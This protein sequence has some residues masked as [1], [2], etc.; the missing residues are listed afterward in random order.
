MP[1]MRRK[2]GITGFYHVVAKGDGA[3]IIFERDKDRVRY[4][5]VLAESVLEHDIA[6]HAYCLMD[7]HVH[8]LV[9]D[10][11]QDL[12]AFMKQLSET[13]ARY[14]AFRTGRVGRVFQRPFWSE[15]IDNEV[16]FLSALRYIHA[17][18]EPAGI[19]MARDYPWSSYK[20]HL[21][22]SPFVEVDFTRELL[23][24]VR[25]FEEFSASG[26]GYAKPFKGST[27]SRHHSS[28]ELVA[29]AVAL[30]GRDA[31]N[32]LRAMSPTE[33]RPMIELLNARGF[34][35]KEISRITGLGI[36]SV[37]RSLAKI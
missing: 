17:N 28:D 32:G 1:H 27:L 25:Q 6:L 14:F 18:P 24:G 36:S 5:D 13:Y 2:L 16:Y 26:G 15:P 22:K 8:L 29:I 4:V 21:S 19:C 31:F 3:Q 35:D 23:G 37:R 33:R 10:N 20:A 11:R 9:Q 7:N 12:S 34:S 30:L